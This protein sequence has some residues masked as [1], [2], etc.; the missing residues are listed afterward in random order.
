MDATRLRDWLVSR[1]T[2]L[3]GRPAGTAAVDEPFAALGLD[4]AQLAQIAGDAADLLGRP[5]EPSVMFEHP[6]IGDLAREL[7]RPRSAVTSAAA[8]DQ[9]DGPAA[10][11]VPVAVVGLACRLPG[12]SDAA[13]FW[14]LMTEALDA[15][16]EVPP[17]RWGS[18]PEGTVR[19][20][21]Y[22][23]DIAGFDS[24]F[25]RLS[26]DEADRMDPQ[27]RLLLEVAW[28]ALEDAGELPPRLR[29]SSTGTFVGVSAGEYMLRQLASTA[30]VSQH[31]VTGC[32]P[33]VVAGRLAYLLDLRGPALSVDTACSSSL[34]A[35]HLAVRA[36]RG[37]ECERAIAAGVNVMLEPELCAGLSRARMLAPDGRGKVFDERANGYV[38]GEG[39]GAVVLKPLPAALAAGDRVYAVIRGSAVNADGGSNGLTAP[40]PAAQRAVLAAAY[41]DARVDPAAVDYVECHGTGTLLGD[42]IEAGAL[43]AVVGL[44]RPAGEPC[45]I[46]SVK[47][48]IGHLEAA[49]GIAGL[50][51]ACLVLEHGLV[52]ASLHFERP[53]PG[54][55]FAGLGLRVVTGLHR[56]AGDAARPHRAGV[57]SFGFSGTN[58]HVVLEAVAVSQPPAPAGPAVLPL[59]ARTAEGLERRRRAVVRRLEA[60][61]SA[62]ADVAFT[63]SVRRTHHRPYRLAGVAADAGALAGA[64]AG[65]SAATEV[66]AGEPRL[67]FAFSGQGTQWPGAGRELLDTEPLF[68]STI[69]RC[70]EM[71]ADGLGWSIEG[72]LRGAGA[73][74]D[75]AD[76]AVAQPVTVAVQVA[77]ARLLACYG[78]VPAAVVGHSVGEIS[79]AVVAGLLDLDSGLRLA[80]HRGRAMAGRDA[81]GSM[82][83][84][85]LTRDQAARHIGPG[86]S[87]AAVNAPRNCVLSGDP[88]RLAALQRRLADDGIFARRLAV[89]YAFHS[90]RMSLA[91]QRLAGALSGFRLAA[92]DGTVPMY[93][94]LSG[95]RVSPG[96]L[97]AAYWCRGVLATV[98]FAEAVRA[99]GAQAGGLDAVLELGG[100]PDL[101]AAL[102]EIAGDRG[103]AV[104]HTLERNADAGLRLLA[105]LGSL[106]G[107]GCSIRWEQRYLRGGRVVS[108]PPYPW[109]RQRHWIDRPP[110]PG[111]GDAGTLLGRAID[112][113]GVQAR[114]WES[115]L[116]AGASAALAD[117]RVA[118][119]VV[120][121]AAGYAALAR[122]AAEQAGLMPCEVQRLEMRRPMSLDHGAMLVQTTLTP[123]A[124]GFGFAVNGRAAGSRDWAEYATAHITAAP[125]DPASLNLAA[126]Q[127]RCPQSVP[128]APFY[129]LLAGQGLEY[130]PAFRVLRD[131]RQGDGEAIAAI[132]AADEGP[133]TDVAVLD[134]AI[135]LIAAAARPPA[136]GPAGESAAAGV[137]VPMRAD[138]VTTWAPPRSATRAHAVLRS[139]DDS[140]LV[141]DLALADAHGRPCVRVD[142]LVIRR[143]RPAA[144]QAAMEDARVCRYELAW[145]PRPVEGTRD[146]RGRWLILGQGGEVGAAL[147]NRLTQAGVH[148]L[149]QPGGSPGGGAVPQLM[150]AQLP[151]DGVV[152]LWALDPRR[153]DAAWLPTAVA[154]LV[155]AVSFAAQGELPRLL[156]VT[157]GAQ[158][159]D[160]G[161]RDPSAAAVW[162]LLRC[163]PL[164]NP[165]LRAGCVDLDPD[166]PAGEGAAALHAEITAPP[167]P[168]LDVQVGYRGGAR[169]VQRLVAAQP[170]ADRGLLRLDRG[171]TY[172]ITG[173]TGR[174]GT[175]AAGLLLERGA[176]TVALLSRS[177][178]EA[179]HGGGPVLHCRVDAGD[180]SALAAALQ[181]VRAIGPIRGVI[182][183]AGVIADGP[184]LEMGPDAIRTVLAGKA[185]GA[186]HLDELTKDDP[187]DWF[188]LYSSAASVLGSPGQA[189]YAAANACLDALA[190]RRREHGRPAL[191]INWGPWARAGMAAEAGFDDRSRRPEDRQ[192]L[193][194]AT[195]ALDPADGLVELEQLMLDGRAQA[196]VL[197]F[198]LQHLMQFYP[199][200]VG[201]SLF[202][203]IVTD[204]IAALKSAATSSAARS[205]LTVPYAAPRNEVERRIAA[206][207]QKS[208]GIEPVGAHD[209]FFELG[210][211]SVFGNQILVEINRTLGVAIDPGQAFQDFTVSH[212]AELAEACVVERLEHLTDE[213]AARLLGSADDP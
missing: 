150:D 167:A 79:A 113:A 168:A 179:R 66:T 47:T 129:G 100:H 42:H 169:F 23:D 85:G 33:A 117:H 156:V 32:S 128:M 72:C 81:G 46:G 131:V 98:E 112:L 37:G 74:V 176:G 78:V 8:G 116:G 71:V 194:T 65:A 170:L 171:G 92:P 9:P 28:E 173:G 31:T 137:M 11:E 34:V 148:V 187:L 50:I 68:A 2:A 17:G 48:N 151:L 56:L 208:L 75:M 144:R 69:R 188:V 88:A 210:G 202:E 96:E 29:G 62:A 203:E 134:A 181:R 183:A 58:A 157:C 152:C 120:L 182:H 108:L 122:Q 63:A 115:A 141:A 189:N 93:S 119:A 52:P 41:R 97:D 191:T 54:I 4:S 27:Q 136:A 165:V 206:I 175:L 90:A 197:P 163:V 153:E 146:Y 30:S 87:L 205:G 84:A 158:P 14:R 209:S 164:E 91:A 199:A 123:Q 105:L 200:T 60:E 26:A 196:V 140:G 106:Y 99:A 82:L 102:R 185:A 40:N 86:I 21:G 76:T 77:L 177:A 13:S 95:R 130:G 211:D 186:A 138:A 139:A 107:L 36:I 19:H 198:D 110:R 18:V 16:R 172:V 180:R 149:R 155:H 45:L 160:G 3:T 22:L 101:R 145:R 73:D 207:W 10:G 39:C 166:A 190:Y 38:R 118:G 35:V 51:K 147:V 125:P 1:V 49:A 114:V 142:G 213:E 103:F 135:Q 178:D 5:V 70:D 94:T 61:P 111:P 127:A 133:L 192:R 20:G 132:E 83:A 89:R 126:A 53:N 12:A 25:F 55:P 67:L 124:G 109:Q 193:R 154:R 15:V 44:G 7:A 143:L 162:G 159:V 195:S 204:D 121:P 59:S 201:A 174:L 24:R 212:L 43:G 64:L 80:V 104:L 184:L 161:V 6:T 57:S